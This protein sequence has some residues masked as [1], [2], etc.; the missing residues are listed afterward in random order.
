M[1]ET[2]ISHT[3]LDYKL[4]LENIYFSH[5]FFHKIIRDY[6]IGTIIAKKIYIFFIYDENSF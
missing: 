3:C 6:Y 1:Q 2:N 4:F 5:H